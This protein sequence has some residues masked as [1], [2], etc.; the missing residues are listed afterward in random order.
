MRHLLIAGILALSLQA[1]AWAHTVHR[2]AIHISKN[3]PM[4]M[5]L[6][7]SDAQTIIDSYRKQGQEIEI[8]IVTHGPGLHML[9]QDTSPV[10]DRVAALASKNKGMLSFVGCRRTHRQMSQQ[11]GQSIA[12]IE[13]AEM[14]PVGVVEL[15]ELQADGWAYLHP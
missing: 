4:A 14:V 9:R 1:N 8:R 3:D 5:N 6:A 13:E 10:K 11:A 7:L 15:I 2:V 12:L